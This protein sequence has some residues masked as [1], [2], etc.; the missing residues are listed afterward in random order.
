MK[1]CGTLFVCAGEENLACS[2][3]K[4]IKKQTVVHTVGWMGV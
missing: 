4:R 1:I 3:R 2:I